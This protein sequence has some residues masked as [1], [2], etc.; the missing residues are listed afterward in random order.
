MKRKGIL[1]IHNAALLFLGIFLAFVSGEIICRAIYTKP[2][3]KRLIKEQK[4]RR[5]KSD[6]DLNSLGLRDRDY[7]SAKPQNSKRV[8]I[9]GDSF[10]FGSGVNDGSLV[11]AEQLET[12]LNLEFAGEGRQVEILNGGMEGTLTGEWINLLLKAKDSFT[13]DVILIVFFLRDGTETSLRDSFFKPI[14]K[15]L[16]KRDAQSFLY[17]R[18]YLVRVIQ[19]NID[20]LR[21]SE[22][23]S[24]ALHKSYFG[25]EKETQ[26][27]RRAQ[28]NLLTIKKIGEQINA[29][30]ALVVFPVLVE[31]NDNY[32]FKD[33]CNTI[34]QFSS[35]NGIPTHN[36]LPAFM[37]MYSPDLWV[38]ALNQH[39]NAKGHEIAANSILPF[40]RELL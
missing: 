28:D 40:L 8:L 1:N 11:F 3:Y 23:Y 31:L 27:W 37:D 25:N 13:P 15:E 10:T 24:D 7:P 12:K 16:E 26:E 5:W 33:I 4:I 34:V 21:I 6:I 17:R 35:R 20:R 22:Q 39:P 29:R 30:V 19:D 38:S 18:L 36:L 9:L 2:W 14:R 32:P